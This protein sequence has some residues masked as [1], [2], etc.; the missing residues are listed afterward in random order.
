MEE[1][2]NGW[3]IVAQQHETE[4]FSSVRAFELTAWVITISGIL[5]LSPLVFYII[6]TTL[7][8]PIQTLTR[9][10]DAIASGDLSHRVPVTSVDEIG[11]LA[12]AFNTMSSEIESHTVELAERARETE[13]HA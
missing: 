1:L 5:I 6:R 10:A 8:Q 3:G 4:V 2:D 13:S 7:Q 11:N 12:K 9:G